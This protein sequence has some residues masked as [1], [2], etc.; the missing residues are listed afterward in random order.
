ML[1]QHEIGVEEHRDWFKV[2]SSDARKSLLIVENDEYALGFVQFS[3]VSQEAAVDWGFYAAPEAPR[4]AGRKLGSIA[5]D[6]AFQVL[7][8]HKVCGQALDFNKKSILFH[9]A[10]GFKNEGIL[11]DQYRIGKRYH[12]LIL[13][14][15]IRSEWSKNRLD[16]VEDTT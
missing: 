15:M 2:A 1:T 3:S 11:R 7:D 5:L 8:L 10:L 6:Y 14:G 13:F 12:D 9:K 4:G 16:A